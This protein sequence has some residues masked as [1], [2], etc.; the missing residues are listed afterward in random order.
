MANHKRQ[1]TDATEAP[2]TPDVFSGAV[3]AKDKTASPKK[4]EKV[5][6][7]RNMVLKSIVN[8]ALYKWV[9][10]GGGQVPTY[11]RGMYTSPTDAKKAMDRYIRSLEGQSSAASA[12]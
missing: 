10:Q 4:K 7:P 5:V 8:T 6:Q 9:Y 1:T 2:V 3:A 11:L 12:S